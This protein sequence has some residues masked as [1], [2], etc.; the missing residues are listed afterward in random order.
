MKINNLKLGMQGDRSLTD[1]TETLCTEVMVAEG[2][3]TSSN[4]C[5]ARTCTARGSRPNVATTSLVKRLVDEIRVPA[6]ADNAFLRW[7]NVE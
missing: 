4:A 2:R 1:Y 7:Y 6:D 5:I 3:K